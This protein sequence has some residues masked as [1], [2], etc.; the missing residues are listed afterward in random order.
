MDNWEIESIEELSDDDKK[1]YLEKLV[2][3][4]KKEL[5]RQKMAKKNYSSSANKLISYRIG[6]VLSGIGLL[7]MNFIQDMNVTDAKLISSIV[8]I[9]SGVTFSR[10]IF[11]VMFSS[12]QNITDIKDYLEATKYAKEQINELKAKLKNLKKELRKA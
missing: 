5:A 11:G 3:E 4:Y 8:G 12:N 6:F 9:I 1:I 7:A 10:S 2:S